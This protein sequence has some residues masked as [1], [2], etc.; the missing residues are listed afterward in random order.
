M[1]ADAAMSDGGGPTLATE[2]LRA[3]AACA[4]RRSYA[5]AADAAIKDGGGGTAAA[6]VTSVAPAV[7]AGSVAGPP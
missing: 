4:R 2:V 1:A 5:L 6:L 3:R 7:C